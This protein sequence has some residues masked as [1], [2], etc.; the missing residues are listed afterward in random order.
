MP[1]EIVSC[2]ECGH[3]AEVVDRD[4]LSSA[5]GP[6]EHVRVR[7]VQRHWLFMPADSLRVL[8]RRFTHHGEMLKSFPTHAMDPPQSR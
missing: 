3:A 2:P 8:T 5:E 7:C 4:F 1:P 6:V